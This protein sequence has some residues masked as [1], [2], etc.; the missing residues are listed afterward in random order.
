MNTWDVARW[1]SEGKK[2]FKPVTT[3]PKDAI[4]F[5]DK[6][7]NKEP[8]FDCNTQHRVQGWRTRSG[9]GNDSH[10]LTDSII[11]ISFEGH[12]GWLVIQHLGP[13]SQTRN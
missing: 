10:A 4:K 8:Y 7:R 13:F 5:G 12:G 11:M 3:G 1:M 9:S 6:K 2:V